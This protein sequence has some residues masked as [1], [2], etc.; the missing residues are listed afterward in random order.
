[1]DFLQASVL[2]ERDRL[3]RC[4]RAYEAVDE[5]VLHLQQPQQ[6]KKKVPF[7]NERASFLYLVL[8]RGKWGKRGITE[9]FSWG[10]SMDNHN[11]K[12]YHLFR[13]WN[14]FLAILAN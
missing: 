7:N 14:L 10:L 11:L 5:C 6:A 3:G 12:Q 2:A 9:A 4:K 8:E 13:D 1:M